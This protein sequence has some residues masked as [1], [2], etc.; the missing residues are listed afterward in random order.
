MQEDEVLAILEK[1]P[2]NS[3]FADFSESLYRDGRPET[4]IF[5]CLKGL[6]SNPSCHKGRLLLAKIFYDLEFK[7][8]AIEQLKILAEKLP[9]SRSITK[10]LDKIAP[11]E[12]TAQASSSQESK[13]YAEAEFN[14]DDIELISEENK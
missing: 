9:E 6:S 13:T 8:F 2:G 10:L 1:D 4:A 3:I 7:P 14:F 12:L 5:V 11:G